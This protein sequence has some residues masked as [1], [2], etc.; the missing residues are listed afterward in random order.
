MLDLTQV[1]ESMFFI[2]NEP[3]LRELQDA[4]AIIHFTSIRQRLEGER[5]TDPFAA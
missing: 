1:S 2:H 5:R 4:D 3:H